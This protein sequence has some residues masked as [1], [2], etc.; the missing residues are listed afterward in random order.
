MILRH[1]F[2]ISVKFA[3][4]FCNYCGYYWVWVVKGN[5]YSF[6]QSQ[7]QA[8]QR[9]LTCSFLRRRDRHR[10]CSCAHASGRDRRDGPRTSAHASGRGHRDHQEAC[11][12][13]ERASDRDPHRPGRRLCARA[14]GRDRHFHWKAACSPVSP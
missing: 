7:W 8:K 10:G 3:V 13:C 14:S 1:H 9:Q 2:I 5:S 4:F 11:C 12:A 6:A